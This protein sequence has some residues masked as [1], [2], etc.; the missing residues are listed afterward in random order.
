M[1]LKTEVPKLLAAEDRYQRAKGELQA[2]KGDVEKARARCRPLLAIDK[3]TVVGDVA[4]TITSCVSAA[5]F[6]LA[7]F[8]RRYTVTK[9]MQAFIGEGT[10]YER[11]TLRRTAA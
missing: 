10:P 2:A 3:T 9:R 8:K 11:W 7:D 6:R 1:S 5:T 4:I